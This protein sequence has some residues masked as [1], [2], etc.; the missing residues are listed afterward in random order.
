MIT[1]Y[2]FDDKY[3]AQRS[4]PGY[5]RVQTTAGPAD[6]PRAERVGEYDT[7]DEALSAHPGARLGIAIDDGGRPLRFTVALAVAA[8]VAHL[9][10][11]GS[12]HV[13]PSGDVYGRAEENSR[14]MFLGAVESGDVEALREKL[15]EAFSVHTA[16]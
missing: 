8:V 16:R 4:L 3:F 10:E 11:T 9:G 13:A 7:L 6:I 1:I 2:G 12:Y 5:A 14:E 15:K